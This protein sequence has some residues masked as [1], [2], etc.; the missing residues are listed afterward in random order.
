MLAEFAMDSDSLLKGVNVGGMGTCVAS[1]AS[2]ISLKAYMKVD[3]SRPLYYLRKFTK[4]N[5]K[6]LFVLVPIHILFPSIF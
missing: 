1:M 5:I 2:L 6:F 3:G 4:Y